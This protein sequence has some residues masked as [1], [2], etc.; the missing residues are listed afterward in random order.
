M[1][2]KIISLATLGLLFLTSAKFGVQAA[3]ETDLVDG[4]QLSD[5]YLSAFANDEDNDDLDFELSDEEIHTLTKRAD[6]CAKYHTGIFIIIIITSIL[7]LY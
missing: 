4:Q 3:D 5:T 2:L 7:F 1:Q 6:S